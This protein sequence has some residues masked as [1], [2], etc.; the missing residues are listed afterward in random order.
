MRYVPKVVT[1]GML[2]FAVILLGIG[3][4]DVYAKD[5][6]CAVELTVAG[7]VA[8]IMRARIKKWF[9]FVIVTMRMIE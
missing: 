2:Y 3:V 1:S 9:E 6:I 5:Y 4:G 7:I 8:L